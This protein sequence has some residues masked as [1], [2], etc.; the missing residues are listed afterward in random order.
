MSNELCSCGA[1]LTWCHAPALVMKEDNVPDPWAA[2]IRTQ[3]RHEALEEAAKVA[4]SKDW[5]HL[6]SLARAIRALQS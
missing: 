2:R 6:E 5:E 1:P 3:A 4:L